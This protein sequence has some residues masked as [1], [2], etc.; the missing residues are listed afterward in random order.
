MVEKRLYISPAKTKIK[1]ISSLSENCKLIIDCI[2]KNSDTNRRLL[3]NELNKNEVDKKLVLHDLKWLI[4][5]G[6][7]R[8]FSNG[9]IVINH[10]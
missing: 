8:E 3:F 1:N 9:L 2:K 10:Q 5:E 7:V 4:Q 6:F